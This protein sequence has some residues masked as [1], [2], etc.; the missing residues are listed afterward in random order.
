MN[1]QRGLVLGITS[2]MNS[3]ACM[4]RDPCFSYLHSGR[5]PF[6]ARLPV[7]TKSQR[8]LAARAKIVSQARDR[9]QEGTGRRDIR[10]FVGGQ[11]L[12]HGSTVNFESSQSHYLDKVMR[13]MEGSHVKVF[14][15]CD[16][17]WWC[18]MDHFDKKGARGTVTEQRH[19]FSAGSDVWL[20]FAPVKGDATEAIVQKATELGRT[21][22]K[23]IKHERLQSIAVEA[24]EQC[25][26]LDVPDLVPLQPLNKLLLNWPSDRKLV[27]CD[28]TRVGERGTWDTLRALQ[29]EARFAMLVGPEGGWS[30]DELSGFA[31]HQAVKIGLG[32]R[33][34]RADTAAI[35]AL[36]LFQACLGDWK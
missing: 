11:Q 7:S 9:G 21:I 10:V 23:S 14:N 27:V 31:E 18:R 32:P 6:G 24:S 28:E 20:L 19:T 17:E 16:G 34:L 29:G 33:I 35:A 3:M 5:P 2:V 13:V 36:T 1:R 25:E 4:A 15:G 12:L 22:V 8:Q 30:D 26:R